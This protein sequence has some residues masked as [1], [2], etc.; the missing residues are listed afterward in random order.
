MELKPERVPCVPYPLACAGT[1]ERGQWSL[2]F[3]MKE[4]IVE[5]EGSKLGDPQDMRDAQDDRG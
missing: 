2:E 4:A 1:Q 5:L 3:S